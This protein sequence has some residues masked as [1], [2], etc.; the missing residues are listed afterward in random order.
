MHV[1]D[2]IATLPVGSSTRRAHSCWRTG[3]AFMSLR[4]GIWKVISPNGNP[5]VVYAQNTPRVYRLRAGSRCAWRAPGSR[6][7]RP[8]AG[9]GPSTASDRLRGRPR[10]PDACR[11]AR[12]PSLQC[13]RS[14]SIQHRLPFGPALAALTFQC[15]RPHRRVQHAPR[16]ALGHNGVGWMHVNAALGLVAQRPQSFGRLPA[17]VL[18]SRVFQAQDYG[19][20]AIMRCCVHYKCTEGD[21][22]FKI[23]CRPVHRRGRQLVHPKDESKRQ[24]CQAHKDYRNS[25]NIKGFSSQALNALDLYITACI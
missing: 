9:S 18:V 7:A 14:P 20:G 11:A 17:E 15:V 22:L 1:A 16:R 5:S 19:G 4:A 8:V 13:A 6:P 23:R 24:N 12:A 21:Q 10:T 3:R 2:T 25:L